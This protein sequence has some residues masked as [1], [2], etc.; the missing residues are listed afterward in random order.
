MRNDDALEVLT[1]E[2]VRIRLHPAGFWGRFL[3]F[4]IDFSLIVAL[5]VL[6]SLLS[7]VLDIAGIGFLLSATFGFLVMWGYHVYFE[8]YRQGRSPGKR[9]I[10]LRVVDR[11]GL[12]ISVGQSFARNMLRALDVLPLAYGVGAM[13]CLFDRHGRRLGDIIADTVVVRETTSIEYAGQLAKERRHNSLQTPQVRRL[14]RHR[15]GLEEREFLLTLCLRSERL[16]SRPRYDLM[17]EVGRHY[18]ATLEIDD[19]HLSG[20]NLVRG[21]T[22]VLFEQK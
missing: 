6:C 3:A 12:P 20:E 16:E 5:V 19:P 13:A 18:K 8:V 4:G 22:A 7:H 1:P 9:A 11:R 2:H 17:E 15:I 10:G 21:L 14:I